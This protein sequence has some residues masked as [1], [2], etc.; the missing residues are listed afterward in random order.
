[1]FDFYFSKMDE[2]NEKERLA[3]ILPSHELFHQSMV[4]A[5]CESQLFRDNSRGL[6]GGAYFQAT[7]L[8]RKEAKSGKGK[9]SI[10]ALKDMIL[11]KADVRF[12]HTFI[13]THGLDPNFD[14]TP[15][16]IK[17][18]SRE[19]KA[20]YLYQKVADTLKD[21]LPEFKNCRL[22]DP[23][24]ADHPLQEGRRAKYKV[25]HETH[26]RE[27]EL[28][29]EPFI[30]DDSESIRDLF[31]NYKNGEF[32]LDAIFALTDNFEKYGDGLGCYVV[33]KLLLPI[34][35]GLKHSNYS[36]SVHRFIT[37]I[38]C[39]ATPKEGLKLMYEKFRKVFSKRNIQV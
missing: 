8:Q 12:N 39:E 21:L 7:I 10:D 25:S 20:N 29:E 6:E 5:D 1:M 22:E 28:P 19:K 9:D 14:N 32:F 33:N 37:R 27:K 30:E 13:M 23:G 2:V 11:L 36:N 16:L 31:W 4:V 26:S 15:P 18:A 38:N 17:S 34:F 35:H 24:L 3:F